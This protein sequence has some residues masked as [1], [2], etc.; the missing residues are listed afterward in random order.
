MSGGKQTPRQK[1]IGMMYLVLT[2]LL[3]L[4]V[5]KDILDAFVRVNKG[6]EITNESFTEQ[7]AKL[8]SEFDKQMAINPAK[9]KPYYDA[10]QKAK[11]NA[12]KMY[13]WIYELKKE[14]IMAVDK[15]TPEEAEAAI[16]NCALV[17]GKDNYDI[18]THEMLGDGTNIEIGKAH[19]LKV[20]LEE[21]RDGLLD[22]VK[23]ENLVIPNL[24]QVLADLGTIGINTSDPT[25]DELSEQEKKDP[26]AKKWET[27]NFY[28]NVIVA[29]VTILTN[30]QNDVRNAES[31]I[32]NTL[33]AQISAS[34]FKFDT[35][36]PKVIPN[37]SYILQGEQ[38]TA[39]LFVAAFST[40]DTPRVFVGDGWDSIKGELTGT[41]VEVPVKRGVG[42]Y[43]VQATGT[44]ERKFSALIK[45]KKP[46]LDGS[47]E[48]HWKKYP[49]PS[50]EYRVAPPSVVVSPTKMN[51]LYRGI[52]NPI[53]ISAAG[54]ETEALSP[55]GSNVTLRS[56]GKAG[57]Y[58]A[59][60][61]NGSSA[62]IS[63]SAK[64]ETGTKSLGKMDFRVAD[65]P[66]PI[67]K[68]GG[69]KGGAIKRNEL[70]AQNKVD[71]VLESFAFDLTFN[72]ISFKCTMKNKQGFWDDKENRGGTFN[73]DVRDMV[74]KVS[75]G[76]K[77]FFED[78]KA[79]GPD[80]KLR[81][82]GSVTFTVI[83]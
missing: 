23:D 16:E 7:N 24:E 78:I 50:I 2:A 6:L 9:T 11:E 29:T 68:I 60:P 31:R 32:I 57:D 18:P 59:R 46:G 43:K 30:F 77:I 82:L 27:R 21:Y 48:E 80:G 14:L 69:K 55:S 71:A 13:E 39:D 47:K 19:E 12:Q 52:D 8:Y 35:L 54:M 26:M 4:N 74:N 45:V 70:K 79:K 83:P 81:D 67:A 65:V 22:L 15:C 62:T 58:I 34:D 56:A 20:K 63:V 75:P 28:H 76:Q 3:A 41:T 51:M 17:M 49:I 1:M 44:G 66:D 40:T 72:I 10:A 53:S 73:G 64:T 38:Y 61:G 37:S 25:E 33:L 36:A 42:Q 5:S